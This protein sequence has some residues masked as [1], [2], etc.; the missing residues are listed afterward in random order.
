MP[1]PIAEQA[2]EIMAQQLAAFVVK[3]SYDDLSAEAVQQ[4][5]IHTLDAIGC[6]IG[7]M[8]ATPLKALRAHVEEFGGNPL[9]SVIG[10]GKNIA[11]ARGF[12]QLHSRTLSR[13][14]GL[15]H[16]QA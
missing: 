3:A 14:H 8:N 13:F 1:A 6:A 15:V 16:R 5:K 7:V 2:P 12:I 11:S 10:G 9:V 4:L